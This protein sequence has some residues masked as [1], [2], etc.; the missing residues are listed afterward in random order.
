MRWG[1]WNNLAAP[2]LRASKAVHAD[3]PNRRRHDGLVKVRLGHSEGRSYLVPDLL[4]G[5]AES[6]Y[7]IP[8]FFGPPQLRFNLTPGEHDLTF[9]LD[10]GPPRSDQPARLLIHFRSDW[11]VRTYD[12]GA[13]LYRCV[14][15]GPRTI[16]RFATGHCRRLADDDFA[17]QVFHHT[18]PA[19]A[20]KIVAS[21]SLWS[22]PWNLAGTRELKNVAYTYFTSLP[23]IRGEADLQRIAMAAG[24]KIN[25]Q[26]TSNRLL[27]EVLTLEVYR[28]DTK[29][30][31]SAL[32]RWVPSAM[33]APQ[34]LRLHPLVGANRAYYEIVAPEVVR[35]GVRPGATL[36][37]QA[38]NVVVAPADE[39]RF[40]YLVLG[41]AS[42]LEGLA[43][44]YDEEETKA[45]TVLERLADTNL[46]DF[47]LEHRNTDQVAGRVFEPKVL[48][49]TTI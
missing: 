11:R 35:I 22:S 31:T 34:P 18:S 36:K 38:E 28:G 37:L 44:P 33:I 4:I 47:W 43:A 41:D 20:A 23:T 8:S 25:L 32:A 10:A 30:R 16:G 39:K 48:R 13:Q 1:D 17:L 9:D 24:G 14:F 29:G 45:I 49:Q 5:V 19:S 12:D 7:Y 46:F 2:P 15:E 40:D 3:D 21:Q 6:R 42:T 26:T 27:E